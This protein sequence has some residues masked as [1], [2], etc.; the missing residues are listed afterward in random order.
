MNTCAYSYI[1]LQLSPDWNNI[2]IKII[3]LICINRIVNT[4]SQYLISSGPAR[5][6]LKAPSRQGTKNGH[7]TIS[8]Q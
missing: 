6:L 3:G 2:F 4:I 1:R 7:F 5:R 8:R